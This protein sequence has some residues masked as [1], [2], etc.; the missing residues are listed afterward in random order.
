MKTHVVMRKPRQGSTFL[1]GGGDF[2][3]PEAFDV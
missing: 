3:V 2:G 1:G